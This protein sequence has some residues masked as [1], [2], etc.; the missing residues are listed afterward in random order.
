MAGPAPLT[1]EELLRAAARATG[2]RTRLVPVPLA[3]L[4]TAVRGYEL[5]S[6]HPLIRV[7]Q[8]RRLAEDQ[9]FSIDSAVRDLAYAP[10]SFADG[11][12]AEA[13]ALGLPGHSGRH[14][15][16]GEEAARAGGSA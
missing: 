7:E 5:V 9:S 10:R 8:L 3:P 16:A 13:R 12:A 15:L 2:R 4:V 11:I 6:R 14:V 1:F